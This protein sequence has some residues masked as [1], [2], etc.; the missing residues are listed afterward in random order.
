MTSNI[1]KMTRKLYFRQVWTAWL[2]AIVFWTLF[3]WQVTYADDGL[4]SYLV[5][6]G[7]LLGLVTLAGGLR[8][9]KTHRELDRKLFVTSS[10]VAF[11]ALAAAAMVAGT[12]KARGALTTFDV[13]D[14]YALGLAIQ[15][16][17]LAVMLLRHR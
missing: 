17:A 8:G 14:L 9:L 7:I 3:G 16:S 1:Y 11:W 10:T 12:A 4:K 5:A 6:A 13:R 15:Q 2:T